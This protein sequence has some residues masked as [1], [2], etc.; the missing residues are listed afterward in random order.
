MFAHRLAFFREGEDEVEKQGRL[1][2]SGSDV[3]PINRPVEIVKLAGVFERIGNEGDEAE[4][5]EVG[6]AGSGPAA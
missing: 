3:A 1:Q 5:V 6:R 2:H 4:N